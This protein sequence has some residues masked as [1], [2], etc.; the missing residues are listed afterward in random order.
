MDFAAL[1][2]LGARPLA[3]GNASVDAEEEEEFFAFDLEEDFDRE[4]DFSFLK[5]DGMAAS[6]KVERDRDRPGEPAKGILFG[7]CSI[8]VLILLWMFCYYHSVVPILLLCCN[9]IML[10]LLRC[11][12]YI[13]VVTFLLLRFCCRGSSVV[14]LVSV[15][16]FLLRL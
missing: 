2:H 9:V 7:C 5:T 14:V 12:C 1:R 8:I 15:L 16:L 6:S 10:L 4:A 11:G 3:L 13:V